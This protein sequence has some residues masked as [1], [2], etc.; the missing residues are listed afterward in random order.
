MARR[1]LIWDIRMETT[2]IRRFR[3]RSNPYDCTDLD[4][5]EWFRISKEDV[6]KFLRFC[7]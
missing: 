7:S 1:M 4:F 5:Y 2:R 6:K 3:E